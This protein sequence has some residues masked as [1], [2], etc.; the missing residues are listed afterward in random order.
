VDFD[1]DLNDDP[2][3]GYDDEDQPPT[4]DQRKLRRKKIWK[5]TRRTMYVLTALMIIGPF[6]GFFVAYQMVEVPKP[7]DVAA[8][9]RQVVSLTYANDSLLSKIVPP[10]GNRTMVTYDQLPDVVKHA[11]YAAEDAEFETNPG[12]DI[13]GVLG[14]AWNQASGGVG[15]GSTI[16]QQY[17]KKATGNDAASGVGGLSRKALEVVKAYKMNN[18]YDK[19]EIITAYLNTIYF[20]RGANGIVAAAQ[21]YYGKQLKDLTPSEAALLAGMIQSPGHDNDQDPA[22]N[23][24]MHK[25]WTYVMGQMVEKNWLSAAARQAAQYPTLIG[26]DASR[27][28]AITGDRA[29]IQTAVLA[30]VKKETG[31]DLETL[32]RKGYTIKTTIDPNAQQLAENAVHKVTDGQPANWLPAMTAVDPKTGEIVAYYGGADGN[33]I[34]W[35]KQR[36]EPGSSFKPFD[37]VALLEKGIETGQ[38]YGLGTEYDGTSPRVFTPGSKPVRNAGNDSCGKNCTVALAMKKSI[39]TVFYDITLNT[40][41]TQRVADAA[42]QAGIKAPLTGSSGGAPDGNIAIGGG[43]T[44]VSTVEMASAYATF[45]ANGIYRA[46][47]LVKEIRNPEG[48]VVWQPDQTALNGKAA[49]DASNSSTNQKIARNVTEALLPIADY[50]KVPCD[51]KRPCASKSGTH[52][53]GDTGENAKAWYA[54]YTPQISV[55]VA[56]GAEENNKVVA[57][58]DKSGANMSGAKGPGKIWQEFMNSYLKP[59]PVE[60]FSKFVPIGKTVAEAADEDNAK[61]N[62]NKPSGN[63]QSS[64]NNKPSGNTQTQPGEG[65]HGTTTTTPTTTTDGPGQGNNCPPLNPVCNTGNNNSP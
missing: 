19:H 58:K 8:T 44:Q 23:A 32:Q 13:S 31:W 26:R 41:G 62:E 7:E 25:R 20:G 35:A 38:D 65:G 51:A 5:R 46:P 55:A 60:N 42:H 53:L 33:G 10:S 50:S 2:D 21:A 15:G 3:L 47:H 30:E 57:V 45:A 56:L 59:F 29:H 54:G 17:I 64:D 61:S 11:V 49:F 9:Q 48:G 6:V 18:T 24:Y 1:E 27:P 52:Q 63:N 12:F 36:Q 37:L 39:N 16:T 34:D 28:Q 40:V 4:G 22:D 14:A 43:T